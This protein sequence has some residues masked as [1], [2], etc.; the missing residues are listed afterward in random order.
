MNSITPK[1]Y[2]TCGETALAFAQSVQAQ[3]Q[4][5]QTC[6]EGM[7]YL[8]LWLKKARPRTPFAVEST[9]STLVQLYIL[10]PGVGVWIR[11]VPR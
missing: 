7:S 5:V 8:A 4:H 9:Q 10:H 1:T 2:K 3:V 11:G 6:S